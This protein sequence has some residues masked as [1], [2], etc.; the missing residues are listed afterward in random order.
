MQFAEPLSNADSSVDAAWNHLEN[1]WQE[2][3]VTVIRKLAPPMIRWGGCF[4]S[5]YHWKEAVGPRR[6]RSPMLNLLWEGI[7][8]NQVGT[9]EIAE[10]CRLVGAEPLF[11]VNFESDGR[12]N[13]AHPRPDLDRR[14]TAQE[15]AEW[16]AYCNDPDHALRRK[17]GDAAPYNVRFWQLGNET[18]YDYPEVTGT[19]RRSKDGFT[20]AQNIAALKRFSDAMRGVDPSLK[21]LAWGDDG[22]A[23][24]VCEEAGDKFDLIAFH[25]HY[26]Y[27]ADGSNGPLGGVDY[28]SD[29][30]RT[31]E[32]LMATQCE[33]NRKLLEL[34]EQVSPYAK[35]LAMTEGH[36][37]ISGR[38]RGDVLSTWAAGVAYARILN[39]IERH[40]DV[41]DIA[42]CADFFGNR[43]QVNALMLP[44]PIWAGVPFLMP[45]GQL[46]ALYGRHTGKYAVPVSCSDRNIDVTASLDGRKL[47]LHVVNTRREHSAR[48]PIR[49]EGRTVRKMTAWEISADPMLEIMEQTAAQIEPVERRLTENCY[50][51]PPAGV[52]VI[53]LELADQPI[54]ARTNQSSGSFA[55]GAMSK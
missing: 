13:W 31:W 17:H 38:N 7:F 16:V 10:L 19:H 32:C 30:D 46:M 42:T 50:T 39:V 18:S 2:A 5:Y 53:E 49:V 15:A 44:T 23:P 14:G 20:C 33:V 43:W 45:V 55:S 36:Y 8:S 11:C 27:P 40:S 26:H 21:L 22:W 54:D 48:L 3:V 12:M 1:R 9:A 28:R 35:R 37:L 25:F 24:Q 29:P 51:I 47:F 41:L 6:E 34:K 52:A 4:S